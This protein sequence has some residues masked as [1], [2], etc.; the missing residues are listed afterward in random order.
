MLIIEK[1]TKT[2]EAQ[3][4]KLFTNNCHFKCLHYT[5]RSAFVHGIYHIYSDFLSC[6]SYSGPRVRVCYSYS[7]TGTAWLMLKGV[8]LGGTP[9]CTPQSYTYF[10]SK[11]TFYAPYSHQRSH[12]LRKFPQIYAVFM[13]CVIINHNE[14][15][16]Y[17]HLIFSK[18][19][20]SLIPKKHFSYTGCPKKNLTLQKYC[21]N[22]NLR[23]LC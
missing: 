4:Y 5:I 9:L 16:L 11:S 22:L 19:Y 17:M 21:N 13:G 20:C 6:K 8:T 18:V 14:R 12:N 1:P 7:F 2:T 10:A 3:S 23:Q 15:I